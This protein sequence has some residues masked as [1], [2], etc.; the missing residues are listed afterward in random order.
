MLLIITNIE[1]GIMNAEGKFHLPSG[2]FYMNYHFTF[3]Q[4]LT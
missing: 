4:I 1:Q 3:S 2:L